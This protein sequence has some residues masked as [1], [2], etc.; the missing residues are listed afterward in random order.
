MN[1]DSKKNDRTKS[2]YCVNI[3]YPKKEN[4]LINSRKN[5]GKKSFF[6]N[7]SINIVYPN[8][9]NVFTMANHKKNRVDYKNPCLSHLLDKL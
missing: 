6:R 8:K 9:E 3:M 5:N 7:Q 1:F 4:V 2:F